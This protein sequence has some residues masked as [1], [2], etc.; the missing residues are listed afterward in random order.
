MAGPPPLRERLQD[1]AV[2]FQDRSEIPG[3]EKPPQGLWAAG[4][5]L[6]NGPEKI[7]G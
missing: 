2:K 4:G 5:I 3:K 1:E 7:A 6:L